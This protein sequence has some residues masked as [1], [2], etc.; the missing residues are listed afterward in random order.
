MWRFELWWNLKFL[1]LPQQMLTSD[2]PVTTCSKQVSGISCTPSSRWDSW[3]FCGQS[4]TTKRV[5][6]TSC[7]QF[8]YM[9]KQLQNCVNTDWRVHVLRLSNDQA[10]FYYHNNNLLHSRKLCL[11]SHFLRDITDNV[12]FLPLC[13]THC[14][15]T[16]MAVEIQVFKI[17][18]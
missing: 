8:Y 13:Q 12:V 2:L 17:F 15:Y 3:D 7:R 11:F 10:V 6:S 4:K 1:V 9:H 5:C 18:R 16:N 14:T